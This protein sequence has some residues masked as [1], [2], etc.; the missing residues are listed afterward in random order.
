[1]ILENQRRINDYD[2]NKM[3]EDFNLQARHNKILKGI[4]DKWR[5]VST[6]H[7]EKVEEMKAQIKNIK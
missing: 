3:L 6:L 1:M 2:Y 7:N 5:A 4:R